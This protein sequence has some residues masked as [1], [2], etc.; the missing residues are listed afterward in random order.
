MVTEM[1][2]RVA[3]G[4][5]EETPGPFSTEHR[6]CSTHLWI[7]REQGGLGGLWVEQS[8]G[9]KG[10]RLQSRDFC[11]GDPHWAWVRV[12]RSRQVAGEPWEWM[13]KNCRCQAPPPR[14]DWGPWGWAARSPVPLSTAP[15]CIMEPQTPERPRLVSHSM[16][17]CLSDCLAGPSGTTGANW[18]SRR[19]GTQGEC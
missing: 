19:D 13:R 8:R 10:A 1:Q 5:Q 12:N 6:C 7:L 4:V 18:A 2:K 9:H 14:C 11:T 15:D 16:S 17:V 3:L